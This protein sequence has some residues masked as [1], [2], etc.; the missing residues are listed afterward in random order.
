MKKKSL[1]I[2]I[3]CLMLVLAG[4]SSNANETTAIQSSEGNTVSGEVVS[5]TDDSLTL[6]VGTEKEMEEGR[7]MPEGES[8]PDRGDLESGEMPE[9]ESMPDRG[10]LES[11][12][13]PEGDMPSGGEMPS[14]LDL[15]GEELT[16]AIDENTV[17]TSG[18]GDNSEEAG[19]SD[20]SEG[21]VVSVT[22]DESS[23][24]ATAIT[25]KS[26]GFGG[27]SPDKESGRQSEDVTETTSDSL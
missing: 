24:T 19:I 23:M 12:E 9:G 18:G 16:I 11:G 2:L 7:E 14:M 27:G 1:S 6:A 5:I 3:V 22:Y 8:M 13:M 15:T 26:M 10:D 21:S 25:I 20:M 4:C 17:I